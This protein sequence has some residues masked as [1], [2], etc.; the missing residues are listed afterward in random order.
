MIPLAIPNLTGREREYLNQC[1]DTGFVS[2]VGEFVNRIEAEAAE[3]TGSKG[4]VATSAG[5]TALQTA[6]LSLGV[7]P[8]DM[9][10]VPSFTFIASANSISH[11]HAHPWFFDID[12]GSWTLDP[13]LVERA[14]EEECEK[15]PEGLFHKETNRRIAAIMPVYTLG[16][17]ADMDEFSRVS[18]RY[19]IPILADAACALG[20]VYKGRP[21]GSLAQLSAISL[22]GNK[23]ITA[24][25]GG[26]IVGNSQELLDECKHLS[27]TARITPEYDFDK[28]G[29]NFRMTNL[30]AAVGCAQLERLDEFVEKKRTIRAYYDERFAGIEGISAFPVPE[31]CESACWFSGIVVEGADFDQLMQIIDK[32]R[33][34]GVEARSFWKPVH[35]Q[36][37]YRSALCYGSLSNTERSWQQIITL[38][39]STSIT[40][41]ELR[42]VVDVVKSVLEG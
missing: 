24:G 25:G 12:E 5:T 32:I 31:Y 41:D 3:V 28:I 15:R 29:Y 8:G 30:Q 37:P 6:L 17:A 35:Q 2:S 19:G 23:T 16:N 1:I 14:L 18:E 38:P 26:L 42:C 7:E 40:D 21:L 34:Q 20:V 9:V 11:C 10:I 4:A 22:N 39:C 33:A 36:A 27:T 13:A